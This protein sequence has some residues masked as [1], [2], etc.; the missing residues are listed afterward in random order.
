MKNEES[1][2]LHRAT[3]L[4]GRSGESS[5]AKRIAGEESDAMRR[6]RI[7]GKSSQH[8]APPAGVLPIP[9]EPRSI[10]YHVN[11]TQSR[12]VLMIEKYSESSILIRESKII[13]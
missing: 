5:Q 3:E 6:R 4:I 12:M 2:N 8:S 11:T 10:V 1:I 9:G 13:Y 7:R